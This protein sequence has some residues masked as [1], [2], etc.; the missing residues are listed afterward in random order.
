MELV[1]FRVVTSSPNLPGIASH[2]KMAKANILCVF[3]QD[4]ESLC[5]TVGQNHF[6]G[7]GGIDSGD[8]G[9]CLPES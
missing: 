3:Y 5:R 2:N 9:A 7:G 4:R 8:G 1:A 6:L